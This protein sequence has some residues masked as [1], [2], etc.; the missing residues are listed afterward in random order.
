GWLVFAL[1]FVY[2]LLIFMGT[3]GL[4]GPNVR[5][6]GGEFNFDRAA[7]MVTS[8]A[9]LT[10]FQQSIGANDFKTDTLRGQVILLTLTIA[11]TLFTMIASA[12][13]AVRVLRLPFSDTKVILAALI[14]ESLV[15]VIG[16][17]IIFGHGADAL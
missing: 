17:L 10:G 11:G 7:F 14:V 1:V 12:L 16:T 6:G 5:E 8:A 9:T 4:R 13:A 2:L 15:L 3:L